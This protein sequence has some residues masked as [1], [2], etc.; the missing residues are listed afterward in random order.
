MVISAHCA[1]EVLAYGA[2]SNRTTK[3]GYVKL[4]TVPVWQA[5]W[6]GTFPNLRG[7]NTILVDP[8]KC[9]AREVRQFDTWGDQNAAT[10]LS[11]YLQQLNRGTIIVGVT[12]DEPSRWLAGALPTLGE[13]GVD[14]ADVQYRGAFEFVAQKGFPAKTVLRKALT[15]AESFA[16][17]PHFH[18][19]VTGMRSSVEDA[20]YLHQIIVSMSQQ[21]VQSVRAHFNIRRDVSSDLQQP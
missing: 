20:K 17:Q 13:I 18:A 8:F 1:I 12:A 21:D 9:S 16:D 14:V 19:T 15:Q 4:N 3:N 10:E 5:A 7:V 11:S 6:H 2:N